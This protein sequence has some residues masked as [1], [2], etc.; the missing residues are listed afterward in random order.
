MPLDPDH[1][2]VAEAHSPVNAYVDVG[3]SEAHRR[4]VIHHASVEDPSGATPLAIPVE[5]D[6]EPV[7]LEVD[8]EGVRGVVDLGGVE[9]AAALTVAVATNK[10][11][12]TSSTRAVWAAASRFFLR[13]S[14]AQ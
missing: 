8:G 2:A 9:E 14:W 4:H 3:E 12:S 11:G 13:H 7:F 5:L 1:G 10:V 6:K